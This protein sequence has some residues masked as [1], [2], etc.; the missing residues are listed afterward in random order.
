MPSRRS[1]PSQGQTLA[2]TRELLSHHQAMSHHLLDLQEKIA[3]LL[4]RKNLNQLYLENLI[5]PE[6]YV[7]FLI[8][9]GWDSKE[10]HESLIKT[11]D[12]GAPEHWTRP[13]QP[14]DTID[15][16]ALGR[17]GRKPKRPTKDANQTTGH[18]LEMEE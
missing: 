5:S 12:D 11:H 6:E 14:E 4:P 8:A 18:P 1:P 10:A 3:G 15:W 16:S 7:E 17:P 2:K 9:Q 13:E